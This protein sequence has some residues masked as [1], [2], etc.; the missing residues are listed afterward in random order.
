MLRERI[1]GVPFFTGSVEEAVAETWRGGLVVAPSGPNLANEL[2]RVPDYRRAVEAA[3]VALTDSAV[4]V[5][6]YRAATGKAVPRHSGLKFLEAILADPALK[7]PGT[8]FWVMP[9]EEEGNAIAAWLRKQ[10]F[11]VDGG[12]TYVAPYYRSYPIKDEELLR[13]LRAAKPRVV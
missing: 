1:L 4:M 13:R 7:E 10:G 2:R 3:D 11:P 5:A 6:V 9:A 8:A 12:N